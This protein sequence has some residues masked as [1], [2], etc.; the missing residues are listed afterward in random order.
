MSGNGC[1]WSQRV[2]DRPDIVEV[3]ARGA[4]RL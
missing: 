3:D 2:S 4:L 1:A